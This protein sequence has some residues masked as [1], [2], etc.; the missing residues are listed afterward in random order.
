VRSINFIIPKRRNQKGTHCFEYTC[1]GVY[2]SMYAREF[3][4]C[5]FWILAI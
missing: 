1:V 3:Y 4:T 2:V 5:I